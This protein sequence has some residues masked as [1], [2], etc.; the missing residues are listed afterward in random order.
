MPA[1]ILIID[2]D[3][4][5]VKLLKEG[6]S[7]EDYA[8]IHAMSAEAASAALKKGGVDLIILDHT[9][10]GMTGM[11]FL[12][13]LRQDQRTAALPIIM[14]TTQSSELYKVKG[15]ETGADDYVVKPVSMPELL[16]RVRSV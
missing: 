9:L 1:S 13:I 10:P 11:Q 5:L 2:D 3:R 7:L 15:L 6:L 4:N 16:A 14:L 12:Q 8:V